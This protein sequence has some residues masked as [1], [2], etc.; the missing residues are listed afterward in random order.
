MGYSLN[1]F[2]KPKL[3]SPKDSRTIPVTQFGRANCNSRLEVLNILSDQQA[4]IL[5]DCGALSG[6]WSE[7]SLDLLQRFRVHLADEVAAELAQYVRTPGK[8]ADDVA[9]MGQ[10]SRAV[11]SRDDRI[12]TV[13]P[14]NFLS[15]E[16]ENAFSH[17]KNLLWIRKNIRRDSDTGK[18]L[19]V[20]GIGSAALSRKPNASG[21]T[22]D[23]M[24][25]CLAFFIAMFKQC[26]VFVITGDEDICLQVTCPPKLYHSS[27]ESQVG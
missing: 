3:R 25:I 10:L 18:A 17:Y 7:F 6:R 21:A 8:T 26:R 19:Q 1:E 14:A 11:L 5:I 23:E 4:M 9:V 15:L 24:T 20:S 22:S 12:K 27:R 2:Y 16:N 13:R